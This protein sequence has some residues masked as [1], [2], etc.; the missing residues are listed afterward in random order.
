LS[1]SPRA[2]LSSRQDSSARAAKADHAV[3]IAKTAPSQRHR[4]RTMYFFIRSFFH[5]GKRMLTGAQKTTATV[6]KFL[7]IF[8]MPAAPT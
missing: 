6:K 8:G 1:S 2:K 7:L 5:K 4:R 3:V